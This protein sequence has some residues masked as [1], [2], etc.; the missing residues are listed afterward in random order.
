MKRIDNRQYDRDGYVVVRGAIPK[1]DAQAYREWYND[2]RTASPIRPVLARNPVEVQDAPEKLA[3]IPERFELRMLAAEIMGEQPNVYNYRLVVKD[4]QSRGAVPLHQDIAYHCGGMNKASIFL[5][6]SP[7]GALNGGL[8]FYK[9][10][11]KYGHLGDAGVI[12]EEKAYHHEVVCPDLNPGD[13]V[14]MNSHTWH[15]SGPWVDGPD[16]VVADI[17]WQPQ[18][19]TSKAGCYADWFV[20]SRVSRLKELTTQLDAKGMV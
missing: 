13:A 17:I 7:C 5:A 10:T 11:H 2:H 3:R 19:D 8:R 12:R 14:V 4:A 9:G 6:I 18:K 16:R 1:Q 15:D 20:R